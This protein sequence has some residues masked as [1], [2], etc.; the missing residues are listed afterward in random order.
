M[1]ASNPA[2][3]SYEDRVAKYWGF[4]FIWWSLVTA[5]C[6]IGTF[7]AISKGQGGVVFIG[8]VVTALSA[9]YA[10]YLHN[11]GRWRMIFIIF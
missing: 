8:L 10:R 11:W 9:L 3:A 1:Q 5:L 4:Y 2:V 7:A 6:A